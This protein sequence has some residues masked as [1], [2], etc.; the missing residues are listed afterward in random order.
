MDRFQYLALM[1]LCL[2]LTLPLEFVFRAR[3]Y[4][5]PRRLLR[6][7]VPVVGV[8]YVWDA[9][10]IAR[11]HWW[12][13]RRY[14]TGIE[15]P[16]GVPLE[17]LVFFVAIPL[18]ALLTFEAVRNLLAGTV[19]GGRRGEQRREPA[20]VRSDLVGGRGSG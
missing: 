1:G 11:G 15:L 5:R 12:F 14:V 6:T 9:V 4:R 3:V 17:E 10:A 18:C 8:F 7:L 13:D 16:L 20:G 19:Q 2:A